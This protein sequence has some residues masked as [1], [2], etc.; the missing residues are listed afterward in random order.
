MHKVYHQKEAETYQKTK[1]DEK[2]DNIILASLNYLLYCGMH[3]MG[4]SYLYT[5]ILYQDALQNQEYKNEQTTKGLSSGNLLIICI[6]CYVMLYVQQIYLSVKYSRHIFGICLSTQIVA[7]LY[8]YES[9]RT[10]LATN[11][12][13]REFLVCYEKKEHIKLDN[14]ALIY[15]RSLTLNLIIGVCAMQLVYVTISLIDNKQKNHFYF[16]K[17]LWIEF[18][19][20]FAY[21]SLLA[22]ILFVIPIIL[23]CCVLSGG[24]G[25][26]GGGGGGDNCF[27]SCNTTLD[28]TF[29]GSSVE[30]EHKIQQVPFGTVAVSA[31][32]KNN[33]EDELDI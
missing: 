1:D 10:L 31:Y 33:E 9:I 19:S 15:G 28:Q 20:Y 6:I 12:E 3:L 24:G 18:L 11:C 21:Y 8:A 25:D 5:Y 13:K 32:N 17:R 26:G 7:L 22:C 30:P 14:T 27:N 23:M 16:H 29:A 4:I 2:C